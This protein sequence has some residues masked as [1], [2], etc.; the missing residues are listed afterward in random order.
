MVGH[1]RHR[2]GNTAPILSYPRFLLD[3]SHSLSLFSL[4]FTFENMRI[5]LATRE[6]FR[7]VFLLS[8][9]NLP[10][11]HTNGNT[12]GTFAGTRVTDRAEGRNSLYPDGPGS[13]WR[14]CAP[15]T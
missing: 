12:R 13:W 2:I 8:R 14:T 6:I 7:E 3:N 5:I 4:E 11:L 10:P 15:R 9:H 1:I